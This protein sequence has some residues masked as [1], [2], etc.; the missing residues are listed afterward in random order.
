MYLLTLLNEYCFLQ[1]HLSSVLHHLLH[2]EYI[3]IY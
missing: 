1:K 2:I 3:Y